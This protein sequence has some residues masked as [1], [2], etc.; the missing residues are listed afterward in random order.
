LHPRGAVQEK[1]S[2]KSR[3]D[4][5]TRLQQVSKLC[6]GHSPGRSD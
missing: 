6:S 3:N 1:T 2:S 4:D 5:A